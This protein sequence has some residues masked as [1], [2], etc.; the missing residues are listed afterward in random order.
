MHLRPIRKTSMKLPR[1]LYLILG[2]S[3]L[4]LLGIYKED[5]LELWAQWF[6]Q[7]LAG[8]TEQGSTGAMDFLLNNRKFLATSIMS[9]IYLALTSSGIWAFTQSRFWT[10]LSGG[11]VL[12]LMTLSLIIYLLGLKA[13]QPEL[14]WKT[15]Q[16]IKMLIQSPFLLTI[17]SGAYL[18]LKKQKA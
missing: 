6:V 17:L 11:L 9:F 18:W 3:L 2:L 7:Q 14:W 4:I 13:A 5:W 15:A 16:D 1:I 10:F 12:I 8:N